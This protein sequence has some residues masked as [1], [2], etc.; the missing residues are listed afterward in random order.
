MLMK[1]IVNVFERAKSKLTL[2]HSNEGVSSESDLESTDFDFKPNKYKSSSGIF[3]VRQ[4]PRSSAS[5]WLCT[6]PTTI[7]KSILSTRSTRVRR[8][9]S[10]RSLK[11]RSTNPISSRTLSVDELHRNHKQSHKTKRNDFLDVSHKR[12]KSPTGAKS[13]MRFDRLSSTLVQYTDPNRKTLRRVSRQQNDQQGFST[14]S[15]SSG[16]GDSGYSE[17]SFAT[18]SFRRPLHTSCPH[19]HCERRSSFNNYKKSRENSST[20]SSPFD[21]ENLLTSQSYPHIKPL[22][23]VPLQSQQKLT[24]TLAEK[25]RRNLS[26]DGSL[27]TRLPTQKTTMMTSSPVF[28]EPNHQFTT[29]DMSSCHSKVPSPQT[30][31]NMFGELNLAAIELDSLRTSLSSSSYSSSSSSYSINN[32]KQLK[33]TFLV[34]HGYKNSALLSTTHGPKIFS[35]RRGDQVR[36]L[37]RIG[38]STLLVEK[39]DDGVIGFLPQ[40]CLAQHQINS[41][42]SLKGLRET[43]L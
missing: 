13:S 37:K 6:T 31:P 40:T 10:W 42:L 20:E 17:E 9:S 22:P 24:R 26:C 15:R 1:L 33:R 19:C 28:S 12:Q 43:V 8:S 4:Q 25:R 21:K 30:N 16:G 29:I 32:D 14:L 38:K 36:L 3:C 41:F 2:A 7:D 34:W 39:Q 23:K 11:E 18:R 5:K 27:W 35:V